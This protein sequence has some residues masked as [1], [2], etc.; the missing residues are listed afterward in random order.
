MLRLTILLDGE[1]KHHVPPSLDTLGKVGTLMGRT[2][3]S[4]EEIANEIDCWGWKRQDPKEWPGY[5]RYD[6]HHPTLCES[7]FIP[8]EVKVK[9]ADFPYV[10]RW[11]V[12][13]H[14]LNH[15]GIYDIANIEVLIM[16]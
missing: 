2:F 1:Y 7:L 13:Y 16:E 4:L 3:E 10:K 6:W 9:L 14:N 5:H 8:D 12:V 15:G 11:P